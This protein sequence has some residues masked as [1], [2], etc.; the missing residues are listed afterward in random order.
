MLQERQAWP[1][2]R[3]PNIPNGGS[4]RPEQKNIEEAIRRLEYRPNSLARGLRNSRSYRIAFLLPGLEGAHSAKLVAAL[5]KYVGD[6]LPFVVTATGIPQLV[7]R[8]LKVMAEQSIDGL[9]DSSLYQRRVA[10]KQRKLRIPMVVWEDTCG[11]PKTDVV[12]TDCASASYELVEYLIQKG[13][14]DWHDQR[15]YVLTTAK[16]RFHGF[17]RVMEE[18]MNFPQRRIM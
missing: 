8:Y 7:R 2:G 4:V 11:I 10:G 3:F 13:T 1:L 16:E 17:Q 5:E 15:K 12:Q 14:E 6:G 9:T 18:I